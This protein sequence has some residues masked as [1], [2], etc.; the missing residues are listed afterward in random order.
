MRAAG[1]SLPGQTGGMEVL[2][3]IESIS[4]RIIVLRGQRV[5]LD[6]ELA[7]LY[8]VRTERLNEQVRRNQTRF[9]TDFVFR[10]SSDEWKGMYP[11]IAG[12]LQR[13]RRADRL[14]LAFTEHGCL[15][16][17]EMSPTSIL[18]RASRWAGCG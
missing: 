13:T 3:E 8:G 1:P 14:P 15:M 6:A 2:P 16:L 5:M 11:Q 18:H 9:P 10:I 12:T 17:A 7:K 4:G